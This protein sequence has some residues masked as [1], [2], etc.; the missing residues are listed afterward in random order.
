MLERAW[1]LMY[2]ELEYPGEGRW[3]PAVH[4]PDLEEPE[5]SASADGCASPP[6]RPYSASASQDSCASGAS[7]RAMAQHAGRRRSPVLNGANAVEATA[8]LKSSVSPCTGASQLFEQM[9]IAP[10]TPEKVYTRTLTLDN[11][12]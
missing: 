8:S 6:Q 9:Q 7:S 10:T 12:E 2:P 11:T 4:P 3:N 5:A 1:K